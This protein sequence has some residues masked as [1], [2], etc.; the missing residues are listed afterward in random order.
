MKKI[1]ILLIS[2]SVFSVSVKA[3]VVGSSAPSIYEVTQRNFCVSTDGGTTWI[4]VQAASRTFDIAS[5]A[6]GEAVGDFFNGE[7][8]PGTY[9]RV[10]FEP[11]ATFG[12]KGYVAFGG[13][14]YYTSTTSA[15]GTNFIATAS[16]NLSTPPADYGKA[17]IVIPGYSLGDFMAAQ[18]EAK[19]IVIREG[20]SNKVNMDFDISN[21]LQLYD[22]F[23]PNRLLPAPPNVTVTIE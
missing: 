7:V 18:E 21:T 6:S 13:T 3:A 8:I 1:L 14:T 11:G 22:D 4:T 16:F 5:V 23:T 2:L 12:M 19:N 10:K 20:V 9:N 17:S 15:S